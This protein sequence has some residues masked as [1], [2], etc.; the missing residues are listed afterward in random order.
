MLEVEQLDGQNSL[1]FVVGSPPTGRGI[2]AC[3][4]Y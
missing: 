1:T 3:A 2:D 4:E